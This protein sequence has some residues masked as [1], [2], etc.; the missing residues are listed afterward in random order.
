MGDEYFSQIGT[1]VDLVSQT[2]S[3]SGMKL[4]IALVATKCDNSEESSESQA[5]LLE[6]T[7]NHLKKLLKELSSKVFLLNEVIM[8]SSKEV[9]R[10][11]MEDLHKKVAL[12]CS[13]GQLRVAPEEFRPLS[14]HKFLNTISQ[15]PQVTLEDA[16]LHW[17]EEK[18]EVG[19][20]QNISLAESVT[21]GK[22]LN[23]TNLMI[24]DE[25]ENQTRVSAQKES[26]EEKVKS[27]EKKPKDPKEPAMP[28]EKREAKEVPEVQLERRDKLQER[29]T[30]TKQIQPNSEA[31]ESIDDQSE[32]DKI[33]ENLVKDITVPAADHVDEKK[34]EMKSILS[35]FCDYG[36]II[37][38]Q[39]HKNLNMNVITQPM[40]FVESLRTVITHNVQEKFQGVR[41]KEKRQDLLKK[42]CLSFGMFSEA[43][44]K[45]N[46]GFS[47][48]EAWWYMKE[49]GLAFPIELTSGEDEEEA[50][51]EDEKEDTEEDEERDDEEDKEDDDEE[52]EEGDERK[53]KKDETVMIPC[54][55]RDEME[56]KVKKQREKMESSST[57]ICLMYEFDRNMSTVWIYFTLLKEFTKVF[58]SNGG[59]EFDIAFSQK[60]EKR[61]LGIV[62]GIQGTLKW[63]NSKDGIQEPACYTFQLLEY[64]SPVDV[65]DIELGSKPFALNRGVSFYLQ[66]ESGIMT[67]DMFSIL[68]KMDASFTPFLG[69]V[70][71][72]FVCAECQEEGKPGYFS[73]KAGVK[74]KSDTQKCSEKEHTLGKGVKALLK[75]KEEPFKLRNLLIDDKSKL[76]LQA[77]E[78]SKIKKD[79][80]SGRLNVGEQV[81]VYHDSA[82]NPCNPV[83]RFNTYAHVVI[84]IGAHD[85]VHEVVHIG[86]ASMTRG[87]MKAKIRRQNIMDVIKPRDQVFLGHKIPRCE[88]SANLREK[89]VERA[90]ECTEKPSIVFDYHYR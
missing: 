82:S 34:E 53:K 79:M 42:G 44:K 15:F 20:A 29:E 54:L 56:D 1:F 66:P 73:V 30:N 11:L 67:E 78:D 28:K 22:F 55:I 86:T 16:K 83:A 72:S 3:K 35:Y 5:Q 13:D 17:D 12:V 52:D 87:L 38:F 90:L 74:L 19:E 2:S 77:F 65:D 68:E 50:Q 31:S 45:E 36:E 46:H 47:A 62:G 43:Y 24:K 14:W 58:F 37:W 69:D 59:G 84:Y 21:M 64:E 63:T 4:K 27:A 49:L 25:E 26:S 33:E 9:T 6:I 51:V 75:R 41:F 48:E 88:F 71:R 18:E 10:K 85:G 80:L 81:W 39:G 40:A 60:I 57:S 61:R 89:I 23:I 70:Q 32:D 7:K 8:T 76:D